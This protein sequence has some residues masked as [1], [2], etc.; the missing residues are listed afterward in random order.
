MIE[1][2]TPAKQIGGTGGIPPGASVQLPTIGKGTK[3]SLKSAELWNCDA[4]FR[5]RQRLDLAAQATSAHGRSNKGPLSIGRR[6]F[7]SG[8]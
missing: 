4:A 7:L 8:H 2:A 5:T 3:G 6:N 1:K